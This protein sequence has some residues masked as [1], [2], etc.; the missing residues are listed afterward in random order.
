MYKSD[1]REWDLDKLDATFGLRQIPTS[2]TLD[3]WLATPYTV[4]DF[5]RRSLLQLQKALV[6]GGRSWNE[7][8]LENKFISPLIMLVDFDNPRFAYFLERELHGVVGAYEFLGRVDGMIAS[9][10]RNPHQPYFCLS[11]YKKHQE[12]PGDPAAQTLAAMLVAQELNEHR[13]PVYGTHIIGHDW[14]FMLLEGQQ[15][16]ISRDYSAAQDQLFDI[17]R[18]LQGLKQIIN[19]QIQASTL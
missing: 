13:A 12:P 11:E 7:V 5:E 19:Q 2:A 14:Y 18:I 10:F 17:Y 6:L 8:E 15:Y 9:G 1:F 4:D 3:T 16:C